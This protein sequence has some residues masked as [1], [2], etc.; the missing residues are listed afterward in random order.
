MCSA[1]ADRAVGEV[2]GSPLGRS[3]VRAACVVVERQ[4]PQGVGQ[5]VRG[6]GIDDEPRT[7]LLDQPRRSHRGGDDRQPAAGG[8]V[9]HLRPALLERGEDEEVR[10]AVDRAGVVGVAVEP[11]P[12]RSHVAVDQTGDLRVDRPHEQQLA[13]HCGLRPRLQEVRHALADA[14]PAHEHRPE[15][16]S[17]DRCGAG[18]PGRVPA[19]R[20]PQHSFRSESEPFEG[21]LDLG[22]R[23]EREVVETQLGHL[24][25]DLLVGDSM[26][27]GHPQP[28]VRRIEDRARGRQRRVDHLAHRD[29]AAVVGVAHHR[30]GAAGPEPRHGRRGVGAVQRTP[31]LPLEH[32]LRRSVDVAPRDAAPEGRQGGG[33]VHARGQGRAQTPGMDVRS[34]TLRGHSA[35]DLRAALGRTASA[36]GIGRVDEAAQG[37]LPRGHRTTAGDHAPSMRSRG[38]A[39]GVAMSS[40]QMSVVPGSS[41]RGMP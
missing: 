28:P 6:G 9:G 15:R 17:L 26:R 27:G 11:H 22:V 5:L 33:G 31:E 2:G 38:R 20:R 30:F 24:G 34:D 29:D 40:A 10:A 21:P 32:P 8:L 36:E 14:D 18:E 7:P 25:R 35:G 1:G 41:W 3:S 19:E 39:P 37:S 23:R 4:Q 12:S 16:R 13:V